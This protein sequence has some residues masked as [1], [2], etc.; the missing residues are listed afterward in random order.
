MVQPDIKKLADAVDKE[1]GYYDPGRGFKNNVKGA[2]NPIRF[3]RPVVQPALGKNHKE[4]GRADSQPD[5]LVGGLFIVAFRKD[6]RNQESNGKENIAQ[7]LFQPERANHNQYF[8]IGKNRG[9]GRP[10]KKTAFPQK[11]EDKKRGSE[12]EKQ[13]ADQ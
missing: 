7:G 3:R 8:D 4:E 2:R 9:N 11:A 12:H 13:R 5:S 1:R 6:I 10:D